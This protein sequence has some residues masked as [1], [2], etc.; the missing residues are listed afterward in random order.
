MSYGNAVPRDGFTSSFGRFCTARGSNERVD[1]LSL[2]SMFLP[3][4]SRE[5]QKMLRDRTDFVLSQLQHYGVLLEE[6]QISGNGTLLMK[7][8]L[9]G[10]KCDAVPAHILALEKQ[11]HLEWLDTCDVEA[12]S[13][14]PDWVIEKY[15]I[16]AGEQD[17]DHTRTNT[18]VR[19]PFPR[20]SE[21][22][23]GRLREAADQVAGLH[24]ET[25]VGPETQTIFLGWDAAA[26]R[27]AAKA[28]A[29]KETSDIQAR[30][31]EREDERAQMHA[32]YLGALKRMKGAAAR[33]ARSPVGSYIVDCEEIEYQWPSLAN[34][35]TLDIQDAEQNGT[36]HATFN[37][38][39]VT[40]V[41]I[42]SEGDMTDSEEE[43]DCGVED[44]DDDER[45]ATRAKRKPIAPTRGKPS[46][47][48]KAGK[49]QSYTYQL[50]LR[51]RETGEGQIFPDPEYGTIR[52]EDG[53][54]A[55]FA[56][57]AE[58]PCVGSGI[59]FTARKV[60]EISCPSGEEWEEFSEEAYEYAR[61]RRWH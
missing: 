20:S 31:Q 29:N 17:S 23:S 24:H 52:F 8:V 50:K 22:R 59:T 9:Q 14:N 27:K 61:V 55:V 6:S 36:F 34:D 49:N 4:L 30:E 18:V 47:K 44:E 37:L 46:K 13:S 21:Y 19:V 28:H 16:R 35:M 51:C 12:L 5:G 43:G 60:S 1:G 32:D 15:F 11:L 56:A 10:G 2:R 33:K 39:V 40:G 25:G 7:K 26:V 38:G 3:K 58:F 57:E 53:K 48:A 41:M 42:I 45:P 54:F